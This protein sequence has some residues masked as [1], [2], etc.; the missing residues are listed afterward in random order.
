MGDQTWLYAVRATATVQT[1]PPQITLTWENDPYGVTSFSV[2]RKSKTATSWGNPIAV[3][4]GTT[5]TYTDSNVSVGG[6]Y[7]YQIIKDV[8]AS[9][10]FLGYQ[11][12][13]AGI[14]AP[15]I[16]GRGKL[17]LIVATNSTVG[18]DYELGRLQTDLVGDGWQV[19][20]HDVSSNDT[21]A[22]VKSL[23][24]NDYNTD[25][26]N[27]NTVFLFGHVP[28]LESGDLNYD[29]H[30]ARPMPADS[31]YGDIDGDWSSSPGYLPSDVEL[32]VGRVDL[33]NMPGNGAIVPWSSETELL[34]NYLNK[35]HNWRNKLI[36]VPSRAL[37]M[38][39]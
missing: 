12:I 20:R 30:E 31:Y 19:V 34:R 10:G 8:M 17:L 21:P 23:I 6:A 18:L 27:V 33:F 11:Y 13:Y 22:S 5:L 15:L 7:E 26:A 25:P 9:E 36:S 29:G 14:N 1:S 3:L 16:E 35:D 39:R 2:Y 38:A 32:M 28:I 4:S 37:G 24:V